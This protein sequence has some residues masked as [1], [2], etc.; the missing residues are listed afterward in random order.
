MLIS[1]A[2]GVAMLLLALTVFAVASQARSLSA[3]AE[4]SVQTVENLR[5]AS[6]A[7]SELSVASRIAQVA[8]QE[9]AVI[10]GA[11][12]NAESNLVAVEQALDESSSE[13]VRAAFV[14]F[15]EAAREQADVLLQPDQSEATL[16]Q[17]EVATGEAFT[18]LSE[19]MR[20]EQIEAITQLEQDND[21]MNLIATVSTFIVAFVVPSAALFVFQALRSAPRELRSLRLKHDRLARRSQAMATTIAEESNDLR[22]SLDQLGSSPASREIDG[23]LRRFAQIAVM[24]GAPMS[25]RSQP[26][27]LNSFLS[28]TLADE[29]NSIRFSPTE[30]L[31]AILDPELLEGVVAELVGN[32]VRHGSAPVHI[33]SSRKGHVIELRVVDAGT[34]LPDPVVDA[35]F[36]ESDYGLREEAAEGQFGFGLLS[37]IRAV[38]SM[39][40]TL[41]YERIEGRTHLV[42]SLPAVE[43]KVETPSPLPQAA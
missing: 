21:L 24:N 10:A 22:R 11:L 32:A 13:D 26:T 3:Q 39:G 27:D 36:A 6:L 7:R 35:V 4:L 43:S 40:G 2:S 42:I 37:S 34:G 30:A 41:I 28:S 23:T 15:R 5:V 25:L 33:E 38:E 18:M 1:A 8:P 16:N 20:A 14:G 31:M 29:Q 12:E 17:V 9:E 19:A